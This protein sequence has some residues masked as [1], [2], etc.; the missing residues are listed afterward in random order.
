MSKDKANVVI[1]VRTTIDDNGEM[2]YNTMKHNGLMYRKDALIVLKFEEKTDNDDIVNNFITI[3]K[4]K[5]HIKR[6][7]LVTMHQQFLKEQ[8]T[9]NVF[10]HTHGI[11]HMET[12]TNT[13]DFEINE[14]VCAGKLEISY[15]VK[16]NSQEARKHQL[17]LIYKEGAF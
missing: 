4:N 7:G 17:T 2:E 16:L 8:R 13:I 5:V 11:I 12:M 6:T 3:Q 10:Q 14:D 1:E 15:T 9:E